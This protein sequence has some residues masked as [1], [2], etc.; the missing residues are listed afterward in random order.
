MYSNKDYSRR[1]RLCAESRTNELLSIVS[2]RLWAKVGQLGFVGLLLAGGAVLFTGDV[3][4]PGRDAASFLVA[5]EPGA[6][7]ESVAFSP[8]GRTIAG[9]GWDTTVCVWG[10]SHKDAQHARGPIYLNHD[11]QRLAL[12]FSPDGR[13]LAAAGKGSLAVWSCE[14]GT[15]KPLLEKIGL[16]IRCLAFSPD[17]GTLALGGDDG[18][19]RLW[20]TGAWRERARLLVHTDIV[21]SVAFSHDGRRLV[22]S[23]QDRRVMLWDAVRA[24]AIRQLSQ[25]GPSPVQLAAFSPDGK[26]IAIGE[27]NGFPYDV[28]LIDPET[29]TVRAKLPGHAAGICAMAFSPDGQTLATAGGEGCVKLWNPATGEQRRTISERVGRVQ[30][31][32]FSPNGC[33]LAF[34]DID[35]NL[36][37]LDLK[38]KGAR[39]FSRVLTKD[40]A[41]PGSTSFRPTHSEDRQT[42]EHRAET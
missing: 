3:K 35:E 27:L 39:L 12:A 18:A 9:C 4:E 41:R 29:G 6:L 21:R 22:S 1:G 15:Y 32:A 24:V 36:K 14:S 8:D 19:V 11:S 13:Y 40:A 16:T 23:G 31:L 33:Q 5:S 34:A 20:D 28:E 42:T 17:G 26:T 30:T 25:P 38:P 2:R 7:I 10:V 37:I